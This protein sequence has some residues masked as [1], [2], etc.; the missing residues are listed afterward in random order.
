MILPHLGGID[1]T[2]HNA[3]AKKLKKRPEKRLST[4]AATEARAQDGAEDDAAGCVSEE[5]AKVPGI[6]ISAEL[7][8]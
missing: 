7:G 6:E 1:A 4:K 2:A 5:G 8:L 3:A